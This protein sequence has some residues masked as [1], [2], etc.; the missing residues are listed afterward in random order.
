IFTA[1]A[2]AQIPFWVHWLLNFRLAVSGSAPLSLETLDNFSSKFRFPLCEGYGL[3]EASP[4][5]SF[6]P[7]KGERKPGTVGLPIANV[8]VKVLDE[9]DR[10]LPVNEV[11]E[12]AVRGPN[13]ML[14]YW[15]QE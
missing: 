7:I 1:M 5:V 3:S 9:S 4:V 14:G 6:N 15:K 10:E 2:H 12:I 8:E 13:V 11:G